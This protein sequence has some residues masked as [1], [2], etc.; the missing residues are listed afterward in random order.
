MSPAHCDDRERSAD[1]L[2]MA[3]FDHPVPVR[4]IVA[5]AAFAVVVIGLSTWFA[6]SAVAAESRRRQE[7]SVAERVEAMV[8]F[9]DT[10]STEEVGTAE[11]WARLPEIGRLT[12][13]LLLVDGDGGALARHRAQADLRA[14]LE[15]IVDSR[16]YVGYFVVDRMGHNVAS[17]HDADLALLNDVEAFDPRR[18][19]R[20]AR[21]E[22]LMVVPQEPGGGTFADPDD[23][24]RSTPM[25][26]VG[27]PISDDA[28]SVDAVLLLQI[29]VEATLIPVFAQSRW[30]RT[31]ELYAV[32]SDGR[33][34]TASRF[35]DIVVTGGLVT[36]S[37]PGA[38]AV[39]DPGVDLTAGSR[40]EP[41]QSGPLTDAAAGVLQGWDS[42]GTYDNY[43]GHPVVG[44]WRWIDEL[45]LGV[46]AEQSEGEVYGE[47]RRSRIAVVAVAAVASALLVGVVGVAVSWRRQV[48]GGRSF[49]AEQIQ[50]FL[51]VLDQSSDGLV[52][53]GADRRL[54]FINNGAEEMFGLAASDVVGLDLSLLVAPED[55][56]TNRET[57]DRYLTDPE[58]R[59]GPVMLR[60]VARRTD[61][62]TFHAEVRMMAVDIDERET[63]FVFSV[64][65]VTSDD[66]LRSAH[67]NIR[68]LRRL[69]WVAGHDLQEPLRKIQTF[70]AMLADSVGTGPTEEGF[71]VEAMGDEVGRMRSLVDG[72]CV[73]SDAALSTFE[74][75]PVDL[76]ALVWQVVDEMDSQFVASGARIDVERLPTVIGDAPQLH[77]LFRELLENAQRFRRPDADLRVRIGSEPG[78]DA[79]FHRI[80]VADNGRGF[81]QAN[82]EQVFDVFKQLHPVGV[83]GG[84]GV[85]LAVARRIVERHGGSIRVSAEVDRGAVFN[86]WLRRADDPR[87]TRVPV[88]GLTGSCAI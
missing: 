20:L 1:P 14:A 33:M 82:A 17:S 3:S 2:H 42:V 28:G 9:L 23:P 24:V 7:V 77:R 86:I 79:G 51:T 13:E 5:A 36:E 70:A 44:T 22:A 76:E 34:I 73:Y 41:G 29:D 63:V 75:G 59:A 65:D 48:D 85:G 35:E 62:S 19:G 40:V 12:R 30:G 55:R 26:F 38:L 32:G 4:G 53:A 68:E 11:A 74:P 69:N 88:N 71:L 18:M 84:I 39:R 27:A 81:D 87:A 47:W 25:I 57:V 67:E 43:L 56:Q 31:G 61:G 80:V 52:I 72:L 50:R 83:D 6:L 58:S 21:G 16:G 46:V 45:G 15:P 78:D 60:V 8:A 64:R 49:A 54:V 10:W 66:N 37:S